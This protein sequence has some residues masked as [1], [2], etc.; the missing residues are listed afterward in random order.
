ME[1]HTVTIEGEGL[2]R[3]RAILGTKTYRET[4][5]DLIDNAVIY[6]DLSDTLEQIKKKEKKHATA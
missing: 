4:V 2:S 1:K 5:Q 6:E 3:L